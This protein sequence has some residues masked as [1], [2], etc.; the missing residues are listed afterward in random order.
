[1]V[2]PTWRMSDIFL[3]FRSCPPFSIF[4][5]L[6]AH[7]YEYRDGFVLR[8]VHYVFVCST[9]IP[10]VPRTLRRTLIN[11]GAACTSLLLLF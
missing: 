6:P 9:N 3:L 2:H 7:V 10:T 11:T 1:M 4:S 8:P 5:L